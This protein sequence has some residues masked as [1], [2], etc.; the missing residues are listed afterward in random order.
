MPRPSLVGSRSEPCM[1]AP[2][3]LLSQRHT[4]NWRGTESALTGPQSGQIWR[5]AS[6]SQSSIGLLAPR[7]AQSPR[8]SLPA[9]DLTGS[10]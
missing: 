10:N 4:P 2:R 1:P 7:A 5:S 8:V 9:G 3:G 6:S